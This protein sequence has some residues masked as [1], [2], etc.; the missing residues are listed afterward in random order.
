MLAAMTSQTI[1]ESDTGSI[2]NKGRRTYAGA[3]HCG[4][5]SFEATLDL[6]SGLGKC[7]CSICKKSNNLGARVKPEDFK[8]ISGG[9]A[10]GDYQFNTKSVHHHFCKFCG[11]RTFGHADIPQAGGEFYSVNV[12]CLEGADIAGIPVKY[13]DGLN[14]NWWSDAPAFP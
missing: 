10:L 13:S 11:V 5:V 6:A 9:D 2:S 14:N 3:C 4:E 7:N 8:L 1:T 12:H